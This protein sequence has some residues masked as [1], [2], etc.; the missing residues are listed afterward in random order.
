MTL[1]GAMGYALAGALYLA[2][3]LLL[4]TNWNRQ[5]IVR[6]LLTATV[7]SCLWGFLTALNLFYTRIDAGLL[8]LVEVCRTCG[9]VALFIALTA[10]L[11]IS[12][13][14]RGVVAVLCGLVVLGVLIVW[15]RNT[16][17]GMRDSYAVFV[18]PGGLLLSAAGLVLIEQLYRNSSADLRRR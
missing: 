18:A 6:Y 12:R 5:P 2:L 1:F 11:G 17:F 15:M 14:L 9:W 10:K 13:K 8:T 4:I 16:G 7:L 3:S